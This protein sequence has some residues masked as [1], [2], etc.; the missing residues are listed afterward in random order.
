MIF[1]KP[2]GITVKMNGLEQPGNFH[3]LEELLPKDELEME[4]AFS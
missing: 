4:M 2:K 3:I 1:P